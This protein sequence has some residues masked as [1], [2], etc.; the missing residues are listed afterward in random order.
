MFLI[1]IDHHIPCML[2]NTRQPSLVVYPDQ[3][4]APAYFFIELASSLATACTDRYVFAVFA[5]TH[6]RNRSSALYEIRLIS[7]FRV[8]FNLYSQKTAMVSKLNVPSRVGV[9]RV[10]HG[11][12]RA[13]CQVTSLWPRFLL[14]LPSSTFFCCMTDSLCIALSVLQAP[15]S[16]LPFTHPKVTGTVWLAGTACTIA[17]LASPVPVVEAADLG[18]GQTVFNNSCGQCNIFL[19]TENCI[20]SL[21]TSVF[22]FTPHHL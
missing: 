7:P 3:I 12:N 9:A 5:G 8:C 19:S 10:G 1:F 13:T 15:P 17:L 6:A 16:G 18:K 14:T 11:E 22:H 2:R 21:A 4:L 20:C